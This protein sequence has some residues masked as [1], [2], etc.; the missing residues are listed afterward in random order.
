MNAAGMP[1]SEL[2]NERGGFK[3]Y[4]YVFWSMG[5]KSYKNREFLHSVFPHKRGLVDS[6]QFTLDQ[7]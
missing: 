3:K 1:I 5:C 2:Q 6:F 7:S 4:L